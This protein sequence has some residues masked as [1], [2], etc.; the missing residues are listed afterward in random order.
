MSILYEILRFIRFY[1]RTLSK[2]YKS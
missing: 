2:I 1:V